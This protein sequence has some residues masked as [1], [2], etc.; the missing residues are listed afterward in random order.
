MRT[1]TPVLRSISLSA[2]LISFLC[3]CNCAFSNIEDLD[4]GTGRPGI[5]NRAFELYD[6]EG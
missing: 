2:L 4:D 5:R 1:N 6:G 3:T